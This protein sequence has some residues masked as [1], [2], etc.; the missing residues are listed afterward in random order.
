ML[1]LGITRDGKVGRARQV[2]LVKAWQAALRKQG[3]AVRH[4][5]ADRA[6]QGQAGRQD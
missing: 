2:V 6:K 3:Y 5:E 1:G 4:S